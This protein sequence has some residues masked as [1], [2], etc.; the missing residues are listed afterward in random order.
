MVSETVFLGVVTYRGTR[1]PASATPQGLAFR[2]AAR[3]DQAGLATIIE[4]HQDDAFDPSSI[5]LDPAQV[6]ASIV[7]ELAVEAD[8]R[9]GLSP[10]TP[11]WAM[12]TFMTARRAYRRLRLCPPWRTH[13]SAGDPGPR[14]LIRLANIELAHLALMRAAVDAEADWALIVEDDAVAEDPDEFADSL[15]RFISEHGSTR[16]PRYVNVSR[17]FSERRLRTGGHA[18]VVGTWSAGEGARSRS[19]PRSGR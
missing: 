14:M 2:V 18:D 6:R 7:A 8:W 9:L 10:G 3:L 13:L 11:R 16:Q 4:V 1:Y 12:S 5:D 15:A 17:S 19:R